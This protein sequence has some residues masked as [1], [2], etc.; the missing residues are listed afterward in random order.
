MT[1]PKGPI[2]VLEL[3][4]VSRSGYPEPFRSRVLPRDVRALGEPFG[5]TQLGVNHCTLP[6]GKHSSVRHAHTQE[7]ELI[8]MLEGEL[9]VETNAGEHVLRP[10]MV[11]G[12]AAG[13]GDAHRLI[14]RSDGSARYLVMSNRHAQDTA[15]YPDEDLAAV[16]QPDGRYVFTHKDG[17]PY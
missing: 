2:D 9:I 6:A 4:A 14:N 17:T 1:V 10:G 5:L 12:F 7:D 15:V 16:K 3:P 8:Y 11:I 13:T